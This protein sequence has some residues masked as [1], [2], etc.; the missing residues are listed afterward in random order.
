VI[1]VQPLPETTV[2]TTA[3]VLG[4]AA[5]VVALVLAHLVLHNLYGPLRHHPG[6]GQVLAWAIAL[7]VGL[8]TYAAARALL[9]RWWPT[10]PIAVLVLAAAG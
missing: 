1:R 6:W 5:A 9:A 2:R 8:G 4:V 3:A 10:V 7:L